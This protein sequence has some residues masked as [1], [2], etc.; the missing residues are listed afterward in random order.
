M[1]TPARKLM[2][3]D[4]YVLDRDNIFMAS[5]LQVHAR[6]DISRISVL[7][8]GKWKYADFDDA[9]LSVACLQKN[10][11]SFFMGRNGRILIGGLGR[12]V[13]ETVAKMIPETELL[14]IRN[15]AEQI[16]VCGMAGQVYRRDANGDWLPIDQ[17][18]RGKS[19]P[20]F[21]DIG[22]TGPNDLYA[23]GDPGAVYHYD[24]SRWE[25]LDFP[26]NRPLAGVRCLSPDEVYVCGDNGSLF[27]GNSTGWSF[28]GDPEVE[29]NFW[30]VEQ[31][32]DKLYLSYDGGIMVHD[33][34][35]L[36]KVDFGIEGSV[37]CHRLH[38]NDGVLWSFGIDHL[39][40]YDGQKWQEVVCPM[41]V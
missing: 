39:L 27:R 6:D 3:N 4:G 41:N 40:K 33:G 25:K 15:I 29:D 5:Q 18:I 20:H 26:T 1:K 19:S 21:E 17:G 22:G 35:L 11:M 37:D 10:R 13:T 38:A 30:A 31:F 9:V 12:P 2:F 7:Q 32:Q 24:G 8:K 14:R 34:T 28:I 16:Y 36:E 23:I